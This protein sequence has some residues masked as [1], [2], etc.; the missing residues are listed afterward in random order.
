MKDPCKL[1]SLLF[2][3]SNALLRHSGTS[4]LSSALLS[5]N[6]T[7]LS[8][9]L[10]H[11]FESLPDCWLPLGVA[12]DAGVDAGVVAHP[13]HR[14]RARCLGR[15]RHRYGDQGVLAEDDYAVQSG[16]ESKLLKQK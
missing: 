6:L 7:V 10:P 13:G 4:V 16:G 5:D 12:V 15:Q 1:Q 2:L 14:R 9:Y 3:L 11:P 8:Q